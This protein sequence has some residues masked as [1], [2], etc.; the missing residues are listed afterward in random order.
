[1]K[2]F[3]VHRGV[4]LTFCPSIFFSLF[5]IFCMKTEMQNVAQGDSPSA[6]P[7]A[8][9]DF[10]SP[11]NPAFPGAISATSSACL[12]YALA[13]HLS[14]RRS[15]SCLPSRALLSDILGPSISILDLRLS[16][17]SAAALPPGNNS[18]RTCG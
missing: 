15:I 12:I 6:T 10:S 5:S 2:F 18:G 17:A 8:T 9:S 13:L 3:F 16:L 14:P 4:F 7:T 1:M 11:H